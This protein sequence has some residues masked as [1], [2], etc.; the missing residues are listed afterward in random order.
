MEKEKQASKYRFLWR[1]LFKTGVLIAVLYLVLTYVFELKR[2]TGNEMS[3]FVRD[4]DLCIFY[5]LD[6]VSAGDIVVY[7][8]EEGV[9]KVGRIVAVGGQTVDFPEDGGYTVDE[10]TPS[11]Q[12]TYETWSAEN[13]SVVYPLKLEEKEVFILNDFRSLTDDSREFGAIPEDRIDGKLLML[14]RRRNF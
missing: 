14:F 5:K 8:T 4:G 1:F 2:V 9:K 7:H 11:E 12:I 13:S 3:P 6:D 10:Y